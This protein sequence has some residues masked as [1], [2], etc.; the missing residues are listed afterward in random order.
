[1][2]EKE[3]LR[4]KFS[5][6]SLSYTLVGHQKKVT[7]VAWNCTGDRLASVSHDA[8]LRLWQFADGCGREVCTLRHKDEV[9]VVCCD[10]NEKN[11]LISAGVEKKLK[12]WDSRTRKATHTVQMPGETI[13]MD[14]SDTGKYVVTSDRADRLSIIDTRQWRILSTIR[15]K[16]EVNYATFCP[17]GDQLF[18]VGSYEHRS[19]KGGLAF[20]SV[21]PQTGTLA[22][23]RS[24]LMCHT[25]VCFAVEFDP[26]GKYFATGGADATVCLWDINTMTCV[27]TLSR[28]EF[29]IRALS[30]SYDGA[31]LASGCED[32]ATNISLTSTGEYVTSMTN[33]SACNALA[34]HPNMYLLAFAGDEPEGRKGGE[35]T[36]L[37]VWGL[38]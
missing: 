33:K 17:T 28:L 9:D 7:G 6:S 32:H 35:D 3:D 29:A 4:E 34:W 14:W 20:Y 26:T 30:F 18:T 36:S 24:S 19:N 15:A 10:P 11:R 5:T 21:D 27:R 31:L 16:N 38:V 37:R 12:V 23:A 22:S 25:A 2:A 13:S 1:M 8:T